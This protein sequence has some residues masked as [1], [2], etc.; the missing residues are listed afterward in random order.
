[1]T[2]QH[3]QAGYTP[4]QY[5][6]FSIGMVVFMAIVDDESPGWVVPLTAV[7]LAAIFLVLLAFNWLRVTV[8]D[9]AVSAAFAL[10][11]PHRVFAL[12]DISAVEQVRNRW[13]YG[14]GVRRTPSGWMYNVWGFDAVELQLADGTVFRIGTDDAE[15]LLAVV[16][17][18]ASGARTA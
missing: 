11:K 2:Y 5:A 6:L 1:M 15:R 8:D 13:Y 14:W 17:L 9:Q 16:S 10:G 4:I 12:R 3:T 7:F 18:G